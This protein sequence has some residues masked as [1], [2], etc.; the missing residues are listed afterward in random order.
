MQLYYSPFLNGEMKNTTYSSIAPLSH[1]SWRY[2]LVP[3]FVDYEPMG[4]LAKVSMFC[5]LNFL[6]TGILFIYILF[7]CLKDWTIL[8]ERVSLPRT[9]TD[10]L[11][12]KRTIFV[13][14]PYSLYSH[15][16]LTFSMRAVQ[17]VCK[18]MAVF[19]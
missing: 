18:Q 1:F 16:T 11:F 17:T 12:L 6:L 8:I 3:S 14:H 7:I 9:G 2:I 10:K 15:T 19:Q 5:W 13:G 4:L